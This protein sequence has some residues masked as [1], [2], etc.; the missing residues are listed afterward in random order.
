MPAKFTLTIDCDNAAFDE[1][2]PELKRLIRHAGWQVGQ[3]VYA[4]R[5]FVKPVLDANGNRIGQ[6]SYEYTKE[7][8]DD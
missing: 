2:G 5:T 1:P 8:N 4:R 6:W 7:G 3:T